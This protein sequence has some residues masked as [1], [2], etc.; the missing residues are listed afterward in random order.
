MTSPPPQSFSLCSLRCHTPVGQWDLAP[1]LA[2]HAALEIPHDVQAV[3]PEV[4]VVPVLRP[5]FTRPQPA[6]EAAACPTEE[7][8]A[9]TDGHLRTIS[10]VA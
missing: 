9:V 6:L 10:D 3:V 5:E 7:S 1:G 8:D 2:A 4:D